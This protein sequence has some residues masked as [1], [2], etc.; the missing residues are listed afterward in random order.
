M[1][2]LDGKVAI[3]VGGAGGIGAAQA[4]L[5]AREGARVV[6]ADP[7]VLPDGSGGDPSLVD[8]VVRDIVAAG[9]DAQALPESASTEAGAEAIVTFAKQKYERVDAI[10]CCAGIRLDRSLAKAGVVDLQAVLEAQLFSAFHM[11]RLG[12]RAILEHGEGGKIVLC[13][14]AAGF[15]GNKEQASFAAASAAVYALVRTAAIEL[16]RHKIF[17]NA[18][19]PVAKTRLTA[20]LPMFEHV[21]TLT[22][23]HVAPAGLFLASSLSGE[24]TGLVLGVSGAQLYT[25]KLVQTAGKFKDQNLPWT[26]E[27]IAEHWES[28]SKA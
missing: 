17:V 14:S 1:G 26:A 23:D 19:C 18:L 5:F 27:E 22:P 6:V 3:V 9:G 13:T 25:F 12:S 28:I 15:L 20:G 4:H 10:V 8:A 21:D 11:T 24:K 16:Q 2:I 7:G